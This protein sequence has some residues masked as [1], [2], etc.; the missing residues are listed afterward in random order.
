[1][2]ATVFFNCTNQEWNTLEYAIFEMMPVSAVVT[3][4]TKYQ[5]DIRMAE[6]EVIQYLKSQT[7]VSDFR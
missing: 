7:D 6:A 2:Y 1:M 3:V 4:L 5:S